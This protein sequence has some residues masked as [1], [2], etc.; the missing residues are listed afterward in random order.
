MRL[1]LNFPSPWDL[2]AAPNDQFVAVLPGEPDGKPD[3][4]VTFGPMAIKPDEPR[5]W[6][7]QT[8]HS[9]TPRGARVILGRTADLVTTHGWPLRLIE[10][11]LQTAAQEV[12]EVRLCAFYTFMEHAAAAI[13]RTLSRAR[14]DAHGK[15]LLEILQDG[16][17]DW[18]GD[19]VCLAEVWDLEPAR[20]ATS[21]VAQ[22]ANPVRADEA[23]EQT[24]AALDAAIA[25]QPIAQDHIRRGTVLL[26]LHRPAEA[27]AAFEAALTL[28]PDSPDS[29][30][31]LYFSGVAL[32]E[33]GRH[34][35][36]IAAWER[37]AARL[38]DRVD[39]HY[40]IAQARFLTEDFAGA[41][42]G[43]QRVLELEP[44][45]FMTIRKIAQCLYALGRY[46]EGQAA[47]VQ[48]RE[49]WATAPDPRARLI[50]EY[51]FDQFEGDGF[52]VHALETL[53]PSNPSF[54]AVLT[55]RAVEAHG[56]HDRPLPAT[57]LVET[58]DQARA[59]GT[60]F[61]LGVTAG[62]QFRVVGATARLPP[63]AELKRDVIRLLTDALRG[64]HPATRSPALEPDP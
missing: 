43:F 29:E 47:R 21:R 19:P 1:T 44:S 42:T 10:A 64:Q 15:A 11:E 26:D 6:Q 5:Q 28:D 12:L 37:A 25:R 38:P 22:H 27:L 52:W 30:P 17:P 34:T 55:F 16:R 54:Y 18:R 20:Q 58:S 48:L 2:K 39:T 50:T 40:N 7:D 56:S 63:Y 57:V 33:L 61:V 60:P 9:D 32:G 35:D 41:L 31:A 51:V 59:A 23:L 13:V 45:D 8:A 4:I 49:R 53:R 46:E 3:A 24:L 62:P 14:M 36:A